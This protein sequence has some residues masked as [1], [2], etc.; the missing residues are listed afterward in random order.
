MTHKVN[1]WNCKFHIV[2]AQSIEEIYFTLNRRRIVVIY[3]CC[4]S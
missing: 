1:A 4:A 2:F 3:V